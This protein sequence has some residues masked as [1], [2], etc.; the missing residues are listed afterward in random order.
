[1]KNTPLSTA[2]LTAVVF[3]ASPSFA[4]G[5]GTDV[6][7]I[8]RI[9]GVDATFVE[10]AAPPDERQQQQ[11]QQQQQ[12]PRVFPIVGILLSESDDQYFYF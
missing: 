2:L 10:F 11:Q 9:T 4:S 12:D 8:S 7:S 1:M 5:S 6:G 3:T